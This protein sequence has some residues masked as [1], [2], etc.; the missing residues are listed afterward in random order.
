LSIQA[1]P[2]PSSGCVSIC[3]GLPM[4]ADC[5]CKIY[6]VRGQLVTTLVD[7]TYLAGRHLMEWDGRDRTG[8]VAASGIYFCRLQAASETLTTKLTLSR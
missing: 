3:F 6:D 4:P 5:S 8:R 7:E 2:N 1:W